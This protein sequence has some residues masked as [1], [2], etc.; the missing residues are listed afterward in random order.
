ML[1]L[2]H[3]NLSQEP[4]IT[5]HNSAWMWQAAHGSF[6]DPWWEGHPQ[7]TEMAEVRFWC[8]YRGS[9]TAATLQPHESEQLQHLLEWGMK[10][11]PGSVRCLHKLISVGFHHVLESRYMPTHIAELGSQPLASCLTKAASGSEQLEQPARSPCW[12]VFWWTKQQTKNQFLCL[13]VW[14]LLPLI[15][16]R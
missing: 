4:H 7:Q 9:H 5:L 12:D 14:Y 8:L 11:S 3:N 6:W 15:H 13:V 10:L 2:S 1:L 16:L